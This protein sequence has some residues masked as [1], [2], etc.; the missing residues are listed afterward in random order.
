MEAESA[1][2]MQCFIKKLGEEQVQEKEF[3]PMYG[4]L[5]LLHHTAVAVGNK[6]GGIDAFPPLLLRLLLCFSFHSMP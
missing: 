5:P 2:E 6:T 3:M 4:V 1:S